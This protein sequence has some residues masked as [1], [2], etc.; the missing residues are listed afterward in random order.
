[1][2]GFVNRIKE[3]FLFKPNSGS[4]PPF[5]DSNGEM[6][7]IYLNLSW[8]LEKMMQN[9]CFSYMEC[10]FFVSYF[11]SRLPFL[12]V[13]IHFE[14]SK[15]F[16]GLRCSRRLIRKVIVGIITLF[17]NTC[18]HMKRW[19]MLVILSFNHNRQFCEK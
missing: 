17:S 14:I 8:T 12:A 19:N 9:V 6:V 11:G 5:L 13:I 7:R 2:I 16:I 10:L 4:K 15:R 3:V 1:M 18:R